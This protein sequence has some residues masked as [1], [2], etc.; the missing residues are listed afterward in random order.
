MH[1]ENVNGTPRSKIIVD[2]GITW[3][4]RG[5]SALHVLGQLNRNMDY[6]EN[7]IFYYIRYQDGYT[8]Y[9]VDAKTYDEYESIFYRGIMILLCEKMSQQNFIL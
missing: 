1:G 7:T 8:I 2:A 9:V 6:L 3:Q 5:T 4:T